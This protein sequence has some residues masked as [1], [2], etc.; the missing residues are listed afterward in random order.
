MP[1]GPRNSDSAGIEL[2]A[3]FVNSIDL[4]QATDDLAT[5]P[6]LRDWLG[7]R[8]LLPAVST[9]SE[10]DVER[11]HQLRE[12]IRSLLLTTTAPRSTRAP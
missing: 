11:A 2:I 4:A 3:D 7:E 1:D 9:V 10:A 8:D 12:A 6:A 5:A